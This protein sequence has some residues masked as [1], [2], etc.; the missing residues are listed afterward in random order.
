MKHYIIN[1]Q[2]KK[3]AVILLYLCAFLMTAI[4]I[5]IRW[6]EYTL[7]CPFDITQYT[8]VTEQA[9]FDV[10]NLIDSD[11]VIING[12]CYLPNYEYKT[13]KYDVVLLEQNNGLAYKI[14]TQVVERPDLLE[15]NNSL[16][17]D[18]VGFYARASKKKGQFGARYYEICYLLSLEDNQY[19]VH[20]GQYMGTSE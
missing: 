14:P 11:Y 19:V 2:N 8:D 3:R 6:K 16:D 17:F 1:E 10:E 13:I 12:Y 20:S 18:K 9:V 4:Y 7:F 15:D 5:A